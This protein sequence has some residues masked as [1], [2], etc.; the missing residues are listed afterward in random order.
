MRVQ[1]PLVPTR[2]E[3][4]CLVPHA[5]PSATANGASGYFSKVYAHSVRFRSNRV[6]ETALVLNVLCFARL[7]GN[8]V[9][10]S[11]DRKS[12]ATTWT[13]C[14]YCALVFLTQESAMVLLCPSRATVASF[15]R[16]MQSLPARE[17]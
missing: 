16:A 14:V 3:L 11:V 17:D 12:K 2:G 5:D 7:S 1:A 8:T 4:N 15:C 10:F 13:S 9:N 6:V